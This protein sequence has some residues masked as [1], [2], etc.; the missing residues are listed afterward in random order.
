MTSVYSAC[1]T[2][3][4]GGR[5][6]RGFITQ[7]EPTMT[8]PT[9]VRAA[10]D[11]V[12]NDPFAPLRAQIA[13]DLLTPGHPRFEERRRVQD[14]TLDRFPLAIVMATCAED[15]AA[16]VRFGQARDLALAIRS[17]G[18]SLAR[19]SMIDDAVVLD[20]SAMKGISINPTTRVARVQAG[21]TS[22]DLAGPAHEHGLALST[23]D[24]SSVGMGGLVTGG[25]IGFL[26]RKY[27]LAVDNLLS[28]TVVTADG[29]IV[30]ASPDEH[31]DLFWAIRGGGG[32][33]GIVT[34]FELR[35]APVAQVLAGEILLPASRE[36]LRGYLEYTA[37]APDDLTTL[38]NLMHAPP[39]PF[40]PPER[41][42]EP[43]LSVLVCWTGRP[44]DGERALAPLRALATPV[45]DTVSTIP[46]PAIYAFTAHQAEP[47]GWS[48]RSMF[49][50]ALSDATLD[51]MLAAMAEATSPFSIVHL[52]GLGGA[53][54]R[55]G[56][57]ETAFA[58]RDARYLVLVVGLWLDPTEGAD[59]HRAWTASLWDRIRH[60]GRGVYANFLEDEGRGRVREAYPAATFERLAAIKRTYDP[61]NVFRF[62]QNVPPAS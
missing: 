43:V 36:V 4:R 12:P 60:E 1:Q 48:L 16:T 33:F 42:G 59:P 49:A 21:A 13:G 47:F 15:V 7:V 54:A 3:A 9:I 14:S 20:L 27:G 62:N 44:E 5:P 31:P 28:A 61:T 25:G 22:G 41:V 55:V 56:K 38:A 2:R 11:I 26:A 37:N 8:T 24:T 6:Y 29:G 10:G 18:H 58:H 57:A 40:V 23:G 50:D 39:A 53:M 35:L 32:N 52:R 34:E 45:A 51:A 19:L 17:G 46:Y 30:T